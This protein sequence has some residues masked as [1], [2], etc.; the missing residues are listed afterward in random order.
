MF[1][2]WSDDGVSGKPCRPCGIRRPQPCCYDDADASDTSLHSCHSHNA[3]RQ[4]TTATMCCPRPSARCCKAT[5]SRKGRSRSTG[6]DNERRDGSSEL[7]DAYDDNN[8]NCNY[9]RC[10]YITNSSSSSLLSPHP[11]PFFF[12]SSFHRS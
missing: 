1:E 7:L 6:D 3:L 9:N 11:H 2:C 8:I 12:Y 4:W 5:N 10:T